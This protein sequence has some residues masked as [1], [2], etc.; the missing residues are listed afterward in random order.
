[1]GSGLKK[2]GEG[3]ERKKNTVWSYITLKNGKLPYHVRNKFR[4]QETE[5]PTRPSVTAKPV[6]YNTGL[7]R[8]LSS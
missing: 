1:M 2:L 6:L 8:W 4:M 3:E 5:F 7:E